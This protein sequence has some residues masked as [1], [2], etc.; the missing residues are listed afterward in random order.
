[1]LE[2]YKAVAKVKQGLNHWDLEHNTARWAVKSFAV[3]P[4]FKTWFIFFIALVR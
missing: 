2:Y 4:A 1:M 3:N